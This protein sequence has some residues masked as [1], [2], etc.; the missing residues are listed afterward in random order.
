MD[1]L[2]RPSHTLDDIARDFSLVPTTAAYTTFCSGTRTIILEKDLTSANVLSSTGFLSVTNHDVS[3]EQSCSE[4]DAQAA[5]MKH[6]KSHSLGIA[7]ADI[8]AESID[9]KMCLSNKWEELCRTQTKRSPSMVRARG[10][11][12]EKGVSVSVELLK[13][14]MNEYPVMNSETHFMTI[15]DPGR[16]RIEFLR[17]WVYTGEYEEVEPVLDGGK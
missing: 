6:A 13:E 10:G 12:P 16:G 1:V 11:N 14:W 2:P 5:H 3:Y 15:M 4:P 17:G 8:V 9:R 7:M